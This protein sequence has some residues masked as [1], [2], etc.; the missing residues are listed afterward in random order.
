MPPLECTGRMSRGV[1]YYHAPYREPHVNE[2]MWAFCPL[3]SWTCARIL[4]HLLIP[5]STLVTSSK[6][7]RRILHYI[8]T[9][10]RCRCRCRCCI[11]DLSLWDYNL[12]L[13]LSECV[14]ALTVICF[15]AQFNL[16]IC[17][18]ST[19]SQSHSH[20]VSN[21]V[22]LTDSFTFPYIRLV[23]SV[24]TDIIHPLPTSIKHEGLYIVLV[25]CV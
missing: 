15:L 1:H 2:H 8:W 22:H 16:P 3:L 24:A 4:S 21:R 25:T 18:S 11:D 5:R 17:T 12:T 10:W 23:S 19:L 7:M 20:R 6:T 14:C 9:H 13:S